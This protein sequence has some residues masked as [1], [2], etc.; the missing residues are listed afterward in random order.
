MKYFHKNLQFFYRFENIN[1]PD[2]ISPNVGT[3]WIDGNSYDQKDYNGELLFFNSI[4]ADISYN[5]ILGGRYNGL[6]LKCENNELNYNVLIPIGLTNTYVY[7]TIGVPNDSQFT[8]TTI[9]AAIN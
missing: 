6:S 8:F 5:G 4:N 2:N 7:A 3:V 1:N 9:E